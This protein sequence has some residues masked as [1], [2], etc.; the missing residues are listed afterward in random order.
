MRQIL[1]QGVVKMWGKIRFIVRD[2]YKLGIFGRLIL[3]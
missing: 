3:I 1:T 2:D